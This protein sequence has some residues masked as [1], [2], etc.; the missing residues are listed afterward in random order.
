MNK[1]LILI[2]LFSLMTL[3]I[4]SCDK[5]KNTSECNTAN[6]SYS[7]DIVPIF[8]ANG[9]LSSG[10][11]GGDIATNPLA[12]TTYENLKVYVDAKRL[13]GSIKHQDGFSPMPK[14]KEKMKDC[15][16]SKVEAWV[17]QGAKNN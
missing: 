14:E 11:H 7:K 5:E 10:C 1:N 2:G 8:T 9:C 15:D 12:M 16:I 4:F 3:V 13:V 6:M 17:T